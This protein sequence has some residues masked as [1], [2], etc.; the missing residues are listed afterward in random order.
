MI[1]AGREQGAAADWAVMERSYRA[2]VS[3]LPRGAGAGE[4]VKIAEELDALASVALKSLE[5][6]TYSSNTN[7]R[8]SQDER[9]KQNSNTNHPNEPEESLARKEPDERKEP[10]QASSM[11]G[12]PAMP[13]SLVLEACPTIA[14][15]ARNEIRSWRDFL[16]A[17]ELV[18]SL[19]GISPSAYE[20]AR[21]AMGEGNAAC[22]VAAI[23]ERADAIK[24]PG[25]YIR[26]LTG[27]AEEGRF[28]VAP[29]IMALLNVNMTASRR[30]ASS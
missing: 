17:A 5:A 3:A 25:G 16:A 1:A 10:M 6:F 14:S 9:H 7:T 18:R 19:L 15:Y 2:I 26:D 20:G 21:A 12:R 23:L 22:A 11:A 8:A 30:H 4:L 28:S 29:M 13:L 27:K 24:S